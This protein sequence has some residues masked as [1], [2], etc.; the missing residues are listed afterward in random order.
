MFILLL[1]NV[2]L[3]KIGV[4]DHFYPIDEEAISNS[5][6][7]FSRKPSIVGEHYKHLA[8]TLVVH[9]NLP[10]PSNLTNSVQLFLSLLQ[11]LDQ[12]F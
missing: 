5:V 11:L 12:Y 3:W 9:H 10:L 6:I 4:S 1:H 2:F 7:Q 8:D